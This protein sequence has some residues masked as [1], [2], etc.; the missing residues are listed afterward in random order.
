MN[1]ADLSDLV[2]DLALTKGQ[3]ELFASRLKEFNLLAPGTTTSHFR[4]RHKELVKF[5]AMSDTTC[6]CSDVESLMSS[7][8]VE[9]NIEA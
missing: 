2:R 3:A 9:H 4:H 8:R 1:N 7:L 5:F 6:Y